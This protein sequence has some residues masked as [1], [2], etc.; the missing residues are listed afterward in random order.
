MSRQTDNNVNEWKQ[1]EFYDGMVRNAP[2]EDIPSRA[3]ADLINCHAFK[4]EVQPRLASWL[5]SELQPPVWVSDCSEPRDNYVM[6]KNNDIATAN[7]PIFDQS[8]VSCFIAW[9][10]DDGYYHD[11]IIE[12]ISTHQVRVSS[13]GVRP[14]T[15]GCY[16][17]GRLNCNAW[18]KRSRKKIWQWGNRVYTSTLSYSRFN[19]CICVS[20]RTPSNVISAWDEMD[21][22][23]VIGNS[24][25]IFKINFDNETTILWKMNGPVPSVL[26]DGRQRR[27]NHR[28]RYDYLISMS[29]ID[30]VGLRNRTNAKLLQ[31]SGTTEI[32][33]DVTPNRDYSTYWTEKP[34][35]NNDSTAKTGC[36][37]KCGNLSDTHKDPGYYR[38]I[39]A[40]GASFTFTHNETTVEIL[41]DLSTTGADVESMPEVV[42]AI[43]AAINT[44][45]PWIQGK[46]KDEG[47]IEFTTGEE[48]NSS[49]GYLGAGTSGTDISS[50]IKGT[51]GDGAIIDDN[52][53]NTS[54]NQIGTLYIPLDQGHYE[55]H[56]NHYTIWRSTNISEN[57]ADPRTTENGVELP[58]LKFTWC[59]DFRVAAAFYASMSGGIVT[60]RYGRFEKADEGTPLVFLNGNTYTILEYLT[61]RKVRVSSGYYNDDSEPLQACAIGGGRIFQASQIGDIVT[62]ESALDSDKFSNTECDARKTLYWSTGHESIIIEVLSDYTARV[63][64][65]VTRST[66]GATIDPTCRN[67]SDITTDETLRNRMDEKHIGLL[68]M[69]FKEPMPNCNVL[70]IFPG[71]MVSAKRGESYVSYCDLANN[72]KYNAGY[73][74][75]NRQVI[76]NIEG[77]VQF[78]KKA[79]NFFLVWCNDSLW[80]GPTNNPDIKELPEFGEWYAVLHADIINSYIGAVDWGSIVDID[81]NVF[82]LLCQDMGFRQLV[83]RQYSKDYAYNDD[84]QDIVATDLKSCWNLSASAYGR[85]LGHVLWLTIK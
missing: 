23:G 30:G 81:D 73:H 83:N 76:D 7:D 84:E 4:T 15:G 79:P 47:Y 31:Q 53:A 51:E 46:Y 29:R 9:P 27:K 66:Q 8:F 48:A 36:K 43:V 34:I 49:I 71:F 75:A 44:S 18:H 68:N 85:T 55:W 50:I 54:P 82:E 58:P 69:R 11:E 33:L 72:M 61:E 42:D 37:L 22:H 24:N 12:Y 39:A 77:S 14:E 38:T 65:S 17:H 62:I 21:D 35:G 5:W 67:M 70:A 25:G 16:I 6:S 26:L 74:L 64:D 80:G 10:T 13:S 60:A 19:E 40:P 78:I 1:S 3:L 32:N 41:V 28:N 57:G 2:H 45:F 52:W 20:R 56:W 59:G 63:H